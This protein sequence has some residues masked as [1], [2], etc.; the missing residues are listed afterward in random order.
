MFRRFLLILG[1]LM[2]AAPASWAANLAV[3]DFQRA[4]ENTEEGRS[5]QSRMDT[6]L[7][8]RRNEMLRMQTELEKEMQ[9]F[10]S[11]AMILSEQARAD[12]EQE[13]MAKQQRYQSTAMQYETE[14]AQTYQ[15][16]LAEL[17]QKMRSLAITIAKEKGVDVLMD[18]A[19]VVYTGDNV[20]DI[21]DELIK[22]YDAIH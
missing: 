14:L 5:A 12:A 3:V 2:M 11:R 9:D 18:A 15:M 22:K 7:E 1:L 8:S 6:M 17:G 10:Q 13:L 20:V 16:L 19:A 21:T 4:V